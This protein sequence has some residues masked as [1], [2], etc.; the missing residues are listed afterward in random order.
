MPIW[1][2]GGAVGF[3][4]SR[5]GAVEEPW[6]MVTGEAN[7]SQSGANS[8][9]LMPIW[10]CGGAAQSGAVEEPWVLIVGFEWV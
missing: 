8:W 5:S 2:Y 7:R 10:C 4:R 9:V 1:C 6:R 3:E